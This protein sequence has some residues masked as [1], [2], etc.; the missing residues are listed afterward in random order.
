MVSQAI[1]SALPNHMTQEE[2]LSLCLLIL[3]QNHTHGRDTTNDPHIP[4]KLHFKCSICG[5]GFSSYQ[6][7]GGHKSSHRRPMYP[8]Q[9]QPTPNITPDIF[10]ENIG[11]DGGKGVHRCNVCHKTF[12]TG[13]ALGGHKRCHYWDGSSVSMSGSGSGSASTLTSVRDFD[14]NLPPRS[15]WGEEEEVVSPLP[16]KKRRLL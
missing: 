7:L 3:E 6:A 5:K 14:L 12:S 16:V 9:I 2:Y 10:N 1:F 8:D 11:S 4:S 15:G 13:Q